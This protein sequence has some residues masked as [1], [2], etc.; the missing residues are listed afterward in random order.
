MP[1]RRPVDRQTG[2]KAAPG[3][4]P[5][6]L[7]EVLQEA[8]GRQGKVPEAAARLRGLF[9]MEAGRDARNRMIFQR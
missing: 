6:V 3:P 8:M 2:L 9:P 5:R 7:Q 1:S 4:H